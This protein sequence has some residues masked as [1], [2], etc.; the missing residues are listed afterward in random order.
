MLF[1]DHHQLCSAERQVEKV[2]AGTL[3]ALT[4]HSLGPTP[5]SQPSVPLGAFQGRPV[6][7]NRLVD[8]MCLEQHD[9]QPPF[10][11]AHTHGKLIWEKQMAPRRH[12]T[13]TCNLLKRNASVEPILD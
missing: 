5:T 8:P 6:C 9:A 7:K 3:S 13:C 10:P 11:Q 12:N 1:E 2:T 4:N